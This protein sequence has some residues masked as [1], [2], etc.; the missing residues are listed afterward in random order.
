MSWQL[1]LF[2]VVLV[3]ASCLSFG[4]SYIV[5]QS[6]DKRTAPQLLGILLGCG[7]WTG[8]D[9]VILVST[10][11][12]VILH[13]HDIG[14]IGSTLLVLSIFL[15]ALEYT[16]R[17]QHLTGRN[18]VAL[19]LPF[20]VVLV[21]VFTEQLL[22]HGLI[23]ADYQL[24]WMG[25][26][27]V[28]IPEWGP[29]FTIDVLYSYALLGATLLLFVIEY[30][31]E[32]PRTAYR[33]QLI[34][35][36]SL[37]VVPAVASALY[38]AG[39]TLIDPTGLGLTVTGAL[40]YLLLFRFELLD[41]VPIARRTAVDNIEHGFMVL[42]DDGR[43]VD[44]N[45][46]M[47][48]MVG[49]SRAA[50]IGSGVETVYDEFPEIRELVEDD[51]SSFDEGGDSR[52][53]IVIPSDGELRHFDVDVSP[54]Y[55]STDRYVGRVVMVRDVT[56]DR[57]REEQLRERTE[58]L[59]QRNERLDQ[60]ASV[61]SHDLRNPLTIAKGYLEMERD[62]GRPMDY[63]DEVDD[64][65]DRMEVIIKDVLTLARQTTESIDTEPVDL[66]D[67]ATESWRMVD[68]RNGSLSVDSSGRFEADPD[69]LRRLFENLFRNAFDHGGDDVTVTVGSKPGGFYVEDD[70]SGIPE[71][72]RES[73]FEVGYST[74]R[75]GTGFGLSIVSAIVDA[76]GWSVRAA[77]GST[78]GARIEVTGVDDPT[79]SDRSVVE[80]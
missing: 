80:M 32:E 66:E 29:A 30:V 15:F 21:L 53:D 61:V 6:I 39:A 63:L 48:A 69:R 33:R 18:V 8:T 57:R 42:D 78:G 27:L 56:E 26:F 28:L 1:S 60:F 36:I 12:S 65:L 7:I 13:L 62:R 3:F 35:L 76:H 75:E 79:I 50:L 74:S 41:L 23:R 4:L 54:V 71:E 77:E 40:I 72:I 55:T 9:A 43:I 47:A 10:D 51:V 58:L 24:V 34:L 37:M 25:D 67:A 16:N 68:T 73:I 5:F 17:E 52:Q 44:V 49:T 11:R 2:L 14:F 64:S 22:G 59:N 70:G 31:R 46:S 19:A 45:E 20:I 38:I